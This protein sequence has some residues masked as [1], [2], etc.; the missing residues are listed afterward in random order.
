MVRPQPSQFEQHIRAML[1]ANTAM[2]PVA[3][4]HTTR[5]TDLPPGQIGQITRHADNTTLVAFASVSMCL[6]AS[7]LHAYGSRFFR[8]VK[9]C[10]YPN[11][12]QALMDISYAPHLAKFVRYV[13]FGTED[14]GFVDPFH[15]GEYLRG[16]AHQK[17]FDCLRVEYIEHID[18][19]LRSDIGI[20]RLALMKLPNLEMLLVG[21]RFSLQGTEIR[22]SWGAKNIEP[23]IC[24]SDYCSRKPGSKF[25]TYI[26]R[27]A[28][29]AL[30]QLR[31]ETANVR[32]GVSLDRTDLKLLSRRPDLCLW[33]E[34][35][36]LAQHANAL[37]LEL[38]A[39]DDLVASLP[40]K[41]LVDLATISSL[42]MQ[43]VESIRTARMSFLRQL[44]L[45]HLQNIA[46]EEL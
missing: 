22:S 33:N 37:Q 16:C 46:L 40:V 2:P 42:R 19:R 41:Y 9:F 24:P 21:S 35:N 12:L 8:T 17:E 29:A 36:G 18:T 28:A 34:E 7:S 26:Y 3:K 4:A 1:L 11:S 27:T 39:K 31:G 5:L 30:Q 23:P 6:R 20:I 14:V 15:D 25:V 45:P 44:R 43:Y 13:A 38:G 10:L 32:L